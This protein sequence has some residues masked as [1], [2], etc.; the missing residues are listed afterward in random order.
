[1]SHP[2]PLQVAIVGCGPKG[3][4][5][6]ERLVAIA[7]EY[8]VAG[9]IRVD[10]YEPHSA[11]GAGPVY[12][13]AQPSYLRMNFAADMVDMWPGGSALGPSFSEWRQRSAGLGND[14]YPPRADVGRYLFD[15]FQKLRGNV[16]DGM[17]I[18]TLPETVTAIGKA[19]EGWRVEASEIRGYDEV[20]LATGHAKRWEGAL[21]APGG[22]RR[23]IPAVFPVDRHLSP[24]Q[25]PAGSFVAIRGFALTMIDATLALTQGRGGTFS[26]GR[27]PH[28]LRYEE[29][30]D[31]VATIFPYSRTGRPMLAKPEPGSGFMSDALDKIAADGRRALGSLAAGAQLASAAAI[32]AQVAADSLLSLGGSDAETTQIARRVENA[33]LGGAVPTVDPTVEIER[34]IE[35]GV[36]QGTPGAD[37]ALGHS[38]R[39]LYPALVDRLGGDGLAAE[40]WPA[41][42][43]LAREMERI[44][45]GP[46]PINAAKLLAL[47]ECGK[48]DLSSATKGPAPQA[49]IMID[50][51]IPPPGV[52]GVNDDV[53]QSLVRDGHVRAA[54]GRRGLELTADVE[55]VGADGETSR[56]L[57]AIGRPTEDW[58]IGNDTLNRELHPQ[59][60][61]WAR[62]VVTRAAAR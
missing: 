3:L 4:Y 52:R 56:G 37:W 26:E 23:L 12:D 19:A 28:L 59:A 22:N 24:G 11:P 27:H 6:F 18:R 49:D 51:I 38:W 61:L 31:E 60:E 34:S 2:A 1:L 13:P 7:R 50:A 5:A 29:S 10:I 40:E 43:R 20:L 8:A 39:T 45:F 16:P 36:G 17:T 57:G 25:V 47:I 35:V 14:A 54:P 32:V 42:R 21:A 33:I 62:R 53:L 15:G 58:V 30:A 55:C 41:F 9:L 44:S 48:V 46:P